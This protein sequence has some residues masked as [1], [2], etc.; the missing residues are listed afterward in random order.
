MDS[1]IWGTLTT[2]SAVSE[3]S[4]GPVYLAIAPTIAARLLGTPES[5]CR[6][7]SRASAPKLA[8]CCAAHG[9][10]KLRDLAE[11]SRGRGLGDGRVAA[12]G[13]KPVQSSRTCAQNRNTG[14]SAGQT[15]ETLLARHDG[16]RR[17][18]SEGTAKE[19]ERNSWAPA[20]DI[21]V[22]V[23][24]KGHGRAA[25]VDRKDVSASRNAKAEPRANLRAPSRRCCDPTT[26]THCA[27]IPATN[28]TRPLRRH[29]NEP[30]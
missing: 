28:T 9:P 17:W 7:V 1:A 29:Y 12:C 16:Q 3:V 26:T 4:P 10:H 22:I 25:P 18:T 23:Q 15:A 27:T 20:T 8:K 13:G 2:V 11:Q 24:I 5:L 19:K 6:E 30:R 21:E 14:Q